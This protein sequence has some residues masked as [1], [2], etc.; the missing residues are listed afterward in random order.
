MSSTSAYGTDF[1]R[2]V[3]GDSALGVVDGPYRS[4]WMAKRVGRSSVGLYRKF[5]I[6]KLVPQST[7]V[8]D[9]NGEFQEGLFL[10]WVDVES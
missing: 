3:Y 9:E 7:Q 2:V 6:Q 1:Y 10:M 8:E 5:K 4:E